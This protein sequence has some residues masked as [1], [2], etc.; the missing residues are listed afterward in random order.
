MK[1]EVNKDL[2][3]GEVD[4]MEKEKVPITIFYKICPICN[5]KITG[6]KETQVEYNFKTHLEKHSR[7][8]QD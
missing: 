2:K 8:T 7:N 6:Y 1:K 3:G 5:K 4:N